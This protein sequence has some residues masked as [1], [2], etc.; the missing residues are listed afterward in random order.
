M[1]KL[2]HSLILFLALI[3]NSFLVFSQDEK[4][5]INNLYSFAKLYGYVRFFYPGDECANLDWD[6]FSYYAIKEIETAKNNKELEKKLKDVFYP[7]APGIEIFASNSN[8]DTNALLKKILP[9]DT[10]GFFP[11][12]WLHFGYGADA[13]NPLYTS[14][15]TNRKDLRPISTDNWGSVYKK[16]DAVDLKNKEIKISAYAKTHVKNK[17][18]AGHLWLRVNNNDGTT[19]F[20][21]NMEDRPIRLD[22]WNK[23]EIQCEVTDKAASVNFGGYLEGDGQI[24]IDDFRLY[25]KEKDSWIPVPIENGNFEKGLLNERPHE[26]KMLLK[27]DENEE[28]FAYEISDEFV[29]EGNQSVKIKSLHKPAVLPFNEHANFD[30]FFIKDIG[31]SL[32]CAVPNVLYGNE[33]NTFP[34]ADTVRIKGIEKEIIKINIDSTPDLYVRLS[35]IVKCWNIFKHFYPYHDVIKTDWENELKPTIEQALNKSDND[36]YKKLI[37][38][39]TSK[40]YD[41]HIGIFSN[42]SDEEKFVP[43]INWGWIENSLVITES[44]DSTL[45]IR[46]GDLVVTIN[47]VPVNDAL[48]DEEQYISASS[49]GWL[50]FIAVNKLKANPINTKLNLT[51]RNEEGNLYKVSLDCTPQNSKLHDNNIHYIKN[52]KLNDDI[53]YLNITKLTHDEINELLPD[54]KASKGIICDL[55]GYPRGKPDFIR[56]LLNIKD[57]STHWMGVPKIIYPD[58]KPIGYDYSGWEMIPDTVNHISSKI[59]FLIDAKAISYAESYLSFIENYKLGTLIG[60]PTAGTNGNVNYFSIHGNLTIRFTG[61]KV[62]KHN[63]SRHHGI[64]IQPNIYAEPTINGI[65]N[66]RDDVLEKAIDYLEKEI[67]Y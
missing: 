38:K 49:D 20:F 57:T 5:R 58:Y 15:R 36:S 1:R 39:F 9:P 44:L 23:Y 53:Y 43:P 6:K 8:Y 66:G 61:M 37:E 52:K 56:Y 28:I 30:D 16:L 22:E 67:A 13:R 27:E 55:R 33:R 54:I 59:V 48:R 51:I 18:G 46:K 7:I 17:N 21:D 32:S 65:R 14:V 2:I 62:L 31:N 47:D 4:Q 35:G 64:G 50:K 25:Y 10:A 41:S 63:G 3:F 40:L 34:T 45:P 11:V 60:Q 26:W 42:L 12:T 19:G 29:I 24:W